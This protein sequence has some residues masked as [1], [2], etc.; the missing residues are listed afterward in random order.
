MYENRSTRRRPPRHR[1]VTHG[2]H[3]SAGLDER[4]L[5][6]IGLATGPCLHASRRSREFTSTE[7]FTRI[8]FHHYALIRVYQ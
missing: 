6:T 8:Q 7:F 1:S 5:N 2:G 4:F 3:K